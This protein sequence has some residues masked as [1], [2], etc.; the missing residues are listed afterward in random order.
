VEEVSEVVEEV[1]E[2]VV[3]IIVMEIKFKVNFIIQDKI[4]IVMLKHAEAI[5][6][7]FILK[8]KLILRTIYI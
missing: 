7:K 3:G 1:V 8:H 5:F 4:K 2:E 6:E